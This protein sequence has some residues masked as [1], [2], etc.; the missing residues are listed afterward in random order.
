M[1]RNVSSGVATVGGVL[2]ANAPSFCQDGARE[3][4]KIDEEII[5]GVVTSL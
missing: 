1:C 4:F 3:L 2:G 5:G